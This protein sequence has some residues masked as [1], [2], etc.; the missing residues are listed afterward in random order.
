M[1]TSV[2]DPAK[3]SS[4]TVEALFTEICTDIRETDGTSFRLLGLVPLVSG[5][6]ILTLMLSKQVPAEFVML[7]G[8]FGAGVTLGLFR[9]ELRNIQTC[10]WLIRRA[11]LIQTRSSGVTALDPLCKGRPHSPQGIG[12]TAAEKLIYGVTIGTW[13]ALP[14]CLGSIDRLTSSAALSYAGFA[15]LILG[16]TVVSLFANAHVLPTRPTDDNP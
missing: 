10:S 15:L 6:A 13:L 2:S 14:I 9:W 1:M 7:L 8:I 3:S 11:E 5:A 12:K 16:S 4:L